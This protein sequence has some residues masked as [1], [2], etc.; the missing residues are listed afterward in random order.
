MYKKDFRIWFVNGLIFLVIAIMWTI[1]FA[2]FTND[3]DNLKSDKNNNQLTSQMWDDLLDLLKDMEARMTVLENNSLSICK[4]QKFNY[5][6]NS[7]SVPILLNGQTKSFIDSSMRYTKRYKREVVIKCSN[8]ELQATLG[9]V[10]CT[11]SNYSY[12]SYLD[13]CGSSCS[14]SL[15]RSAI[16][17]NTCSSFNPQTYTAT[18]GFKTT[19]YKAYSCYCLATTSPD[20]CINWKW[21]DFK[22]ASY[23]SWNSRNQK[24]ESEIVLK[25]WA[26]KITLNSVSN[27]RISNY[28]TSCDSVKNEFQCE[29]MIFAYGCYRDYGDTKCKTFR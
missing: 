6:W 28:P 20:I 16:S 25:N 4:E 22:S 11:S 17:G 9:S 23:I 13:S 8:W 26:S 10:T 15:V 12:D 27:C 5:N 7:R 21:Y 14:Y 19:N 1:V 2:S 29:S 3:I 18:H 24:K